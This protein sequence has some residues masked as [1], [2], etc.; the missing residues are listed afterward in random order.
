MNILLFKIKY[1]KQNPAFYTFL[2]STQLFYQNDPHIYLFQPAHIK[3]LENVKMI[4]LS[5]FI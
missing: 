2:E 3:F 1:K 5:V 4:M